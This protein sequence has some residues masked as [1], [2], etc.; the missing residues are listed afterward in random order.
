MNE[1]AKHFTK[2]LLND[3]VV[4]NDNLCRHRGD[5]GEGVKTYAYPD[6]EFVYTPTKEKT[7]MKV[8]IFCPVCR[9]RYSEAEKRMKKEIVAFH[10]SL[11]NESC[12]DNGDA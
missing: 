8:K 2:Q 11:A 4:M 1:F 5:F 9:K 3:T 10:A 7:P 12:L 6:P